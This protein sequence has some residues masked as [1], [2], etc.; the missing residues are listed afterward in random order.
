MLTFIDYQ[1]Q[2]TPYLQ[3]N[4]IAV[5]FQINLLTP[6]VMQYLIFAV[7][8]IIMLFLVLRIYFAHRS[9]RSSMKKDMGGKTGDLPSEQ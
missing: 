6:H 7:W 1:P 8:L 3:K 5:L 2:K 9:L 4:H